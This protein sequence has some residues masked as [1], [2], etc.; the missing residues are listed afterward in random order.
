MK[1]VGYMGYHPTEAPRGAFETTS[2]TEADKKAGWT[3]KPVYVFED[4]ELSDEA[5]HCAG[6]LRMALAEGFAP[7]IHDPEA[8][9]FV[10][11]LKAGIA[12][13]KMGLK[14]VPIGICYRAML[15]F[16]K[17]VEKG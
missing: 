11:G 15:A 16:A 1:L 9:H 7:E 13:G 3:E 10:R 14:L 17:W 6:R 8:M 12:E 4:A 2:M 5:K